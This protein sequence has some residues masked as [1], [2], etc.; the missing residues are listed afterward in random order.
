MSEQPQVPA[1]PVEAVVLY[2]TDMA[3]MLESIHA[4]LINNINTLRPK[5]EGEI[6]NA[7]STE[8]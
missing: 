1:V 5:V 6:V 4:N 7:S 8:E 3:K 2:L